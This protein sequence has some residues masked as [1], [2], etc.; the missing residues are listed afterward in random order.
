MV[1]SQE[2]TLDLSLIFK[3]NSTIPSFSE[4]SISVKMNEQAFQF[5]KTHENDWNSKLFVTIDY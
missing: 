3:F 1:Y 4:Y 5:N 2:E